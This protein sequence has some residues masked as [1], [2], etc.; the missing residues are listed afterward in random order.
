MKTYTAVFFVF[1]GCLIN[2]FGCAGGDNHKFRKKLITLSDEEL[3]AHYEVVEMRMRDL[4]RNREDSIQ[5]RQN[6]HSGYD[7]EFDHN[8]LGHLHIGDQWNDLNK[9]KKL[10]LHE[11]R[12]RGL[13]PP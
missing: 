13:S 1:I 8:H 11:M 5:Q 12:S 6:M 2:I 7:P 10:I 3:I 4:D 9:E